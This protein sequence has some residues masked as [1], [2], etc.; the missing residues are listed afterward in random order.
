MKRIL[1]CAS[2]VS[3]INKFHLDYIK[4]LCDSGCEVKVLA[5]G[6]E[7]DFNITD[8]IEIYYQASGRVAEVFAQGNFA[9]DVLAISVTNAAVED[10]AIVK[11]VDVN[12]EKAIIS[13][14]KA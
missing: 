6:K 13:L 4:A 12:G 5:R 8:R 9:Q 3:H 10:A 14:V 7:A 11:E 1:Y 2:T